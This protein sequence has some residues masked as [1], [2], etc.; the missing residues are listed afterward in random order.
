MTAHAALHLTFKRCYPKRTNKHRAS[1]RQEEQLKSLF[2]CLLPKKLKYERVY[3]NLELWRKAPLPE[4]HEMKIQTQHTTLKATYLTSLIA[5]AFANNYVQG[6]VAPKLDNI[7]VGDTSSVPPNILYIL[8]SSGSMQRDYVPDSPPWA[9]GAT[10]FDSDPWDLGAAGQTQVGHK[11]FY[12]NQLAFNPNIKYTPPYSP[13]TPAYSDMTSFT[14]ARLDG[15]GTENATS[16]DLSQTIAIN[17]QNFFRTYYYEYTGPKDVNGNPNPPFLNGAADARCLERVT[18]TAGSSGGRPTATS[19]NFTLREISPVIPGGGITEVQKNY[20]NWFSYYRY[21]MTMMKTATGETFKNMDAKL[22]FGFFNL[23]ATPA[24]LR[25]ATDN[26]R[27]LPV[28]PY[29][30]TQKKSFYTKL[31]ATAASGGTP[32]RE[33]LSGAG[34]YFAGKYGSSTDPMLKNKDGG[35][36]QK[37]FTILTTDGYWTA[38]SSTNPICGSS[39]D[40]AANQGTRDL[41]TTVTGTNASGGNQV[42][43]RDGTTGTTLPTAVN[44]GYGDRDDATSDGTINMLRKTPNQP[45]DTLIGAGIVDHLNRSNTLADVAMYY[46]ATPLRGSVESNGG[47]GDNFNWDVDLYTPG[48]PHFQN[49][50]TYTVGLGVAGRFRYGNLNYKNLSSTE[51]G[52]L[53]LAAAA[54]DINNLNYD[55]A[56][57]QSEAMSCAASGHSTGTSRCTWPAPAS[58]TRENVDDLWHAAVNGRGAFFSAGN[59]S[60]MVSG[61]RAALAEIS[62][63]STNATAPATASRAFSTDNNVNYAVSYRSGSWSGRLYAQLFNPETGQLLDDGTT[64]KCP[65]EPMWR[66]HK[67]LDAQVQSGGWNNGRKIIVGPFADAGNARSFQWAALTSGQTAILQDDVTTSNWNAFAAT[68]GLSNFPKSYGEYLLQY[69][70]GD[71][72]NEGVNGYQLF[73]DRGDTNSNSCATMVDTTAGILGDIINAAPIMVSSPKEGYKDEFNPGYSAFKAAKKDRKPV[74]YAVAND[75]MVHAFDASSTGSGKDRKATSTSGQELWAFIPGLLMH[76]NNDDGATPKKA[77]LPSYAYPTGGIDNLGIPAFSKHYFIDVTPQYND[78]DF[79]FVAAGGGSEAV[80]NTPSWRSVLVGGLAKGGKGF[81][82]LD[83]TDGATNSDGSAL[84]ESSLASK[85]LWEF[86]GVSTEDVEDLGYSFSQPAITKSKKYGWVG[87]ITSGYNNASGRGAIWM[88]NIK[89]GEIIQ[90][91]RIQK[92]CSTQPCATEP[93]IGSGLSASEPLNLG[94]ITAYVRS[95][96]SE[97]LMAAYAGDM[98]GNMWRLDFTAEN[99]KDWTISKLAQV[100]SPSTSEKGVYGTLAQPIT[101]APDIQWDASSNRR[102]V[103]FGTGMD[104]SGDDRNP[105]LAQANQIQS[106]YGI[107][108]GT[109]AEADPSVPPAITRANLAKADPKSINGTLNGALKDGEKG[110]YMDFSATNADKT[111]LA[112]RMVYDPAGAYGLIISTTLQPIVDV[113]YPSTSGFVY[114][115][116]YEN[117]RIGKSLLQDTTLNTLSFAEAKKGFANTPRLAQL[118]KKDDSKGKIILQT[119]DRKGACTNYSANFLTQATGKRAS[120]RELSNQ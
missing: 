51:T 70:R 110:F 68:F 112:E 116:G 11:S 81:Y 18:A 6:A 101:V 86:K 14:A 69:L 46:Y 49:M 99:K 5:I 41:S 59:A 3:I 54:A 76:K 67:Q 8:D 16:V 78:V 88:L 37:N 40:T 19:T 17:G 22:R 61:L 23:Y 66:A 117:G 85:F 20:L 32:L 73:R 7:P 50:R 60:Q 33:A 97:E 119:C 35:R 114:A 113:C 64:K 39:C 55:F 108:D 89:T 12:C 53:N 42:G 87:L 104:L 43:N 91:F 90:K 57:I 63:Q 48:L 79:G 58:D 10:D 24:I 93:G 111:K 62:A 100:S 1:Q 80:V 30:D 38:S 107:I 26:P 29:G 82:A 71:Q 21:R 44:G 84:T 25:S 118:S 72:T 106:F 4:I 45:G 65:L 102:W 36:C 94:K 15:Y 52:A 77:G 2:S 95:Q 74:L 96:G 31:Y 75:G 92:T 56:R 83:V 28:N 34:L 120:W 13:N 47:T 105:A 115:R 109:G 98:Q 27:F 9:R 103:F